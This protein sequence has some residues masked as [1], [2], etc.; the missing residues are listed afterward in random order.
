MKNYRRQTR[1][2][3]PSLLFG[4]LAVAFVLVL[5]SDHIVSSQRVANPTM[6]PFKFQR[7]PSPKKDFSKMNSALISAGDLDSTFGT[8]GKSTTDFSS[9]EYAHAV[10]VQADGKVVA[11]GTASVGGTPNVNYDFAVFRYNANGSLDTSFDSDGKVTTRISN[12]YHNYDA[13]YAVAIQTDGRIVVAGSSD[14][15]G[16]SFALVR[17]NPDGSLD[18]SFGS[19][20]IVIST[21]IYGAIFDI[22]IQPDGKIV[23]GGSNFTIVRYNPNG[24]L[25][26]SFGTGGIVTTS[27]GMDVQEAYSVAVQTDGKIVAAGYTATCDEEFCY[28]DFS[29]RAVQPEW[30][31]R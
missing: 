25:D 13:A 5:T 17:Y 16:G 20:G 29:L 18:A 12:D 6:S 3:R 4:C 15:G 11:A 21:T 27:F 30:I 8:G 10:A 1:I 9:S 24:S 26:A 2:L 31:A 22:A 19:A 28:S 7:P 14:L 23:A